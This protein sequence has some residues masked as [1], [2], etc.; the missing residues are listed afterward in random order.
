MASVLFVCTAN[1]FRSPIAAIYFA[2]QV[3]R[4]GD[5][6]H[7]RVSSAGTWTD[8]GQPVT[9]EAITQAKR[10]NLNLSLHKSRPLT[11]TILKNSDLIL[12]ME[13]NQ[14]EALLQE[15]PFCAE[16]LFLLTE[17]VNG[18]S[19]DIPDPYA[20]EETPAAITEEIINMINRGYDQ[21]VQLS[22]MKDHSNTA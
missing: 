1:R 7:I 15:F 10:Y 9:P 3:V 4:H 11:E 6:D 12:V 14:K 5:D 13:N 20:S 19:K 16:R 21:I 18:D 2:K 8:A 17:V 22:Q